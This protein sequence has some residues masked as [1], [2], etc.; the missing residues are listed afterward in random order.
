MIASLAIALII[1][2]ATM[3]LV[4][5]ASVRLRNAGIVDVAWSA[6]FGVIALVYGV[7]GDAPPARRAVAAG[8]MMLWSARLAIHLW[9]R[10]GKHLEQ[11]DGRYAALRERWGERADRR[12]FWFFQFQ[13]LT[14]V[15]LSVPIVLACNHRDP[16]FHLLEWAAVGLWLVAL[17]GESLADAQLRHIKASPANRGLVMDRGLW[18][19]SRHPNY[20][21]EWLIWCSFALFAL[22][23][24]YGWVALLSPALMLWFLLRVTGIPATEEQSLRSRGEA[25]RRYQETTSAFVPLPPKPRERK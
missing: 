25:Y 2:S 20:F 15:A 22:T 5:L 4:W 16:G 1:A 14:N 11:E 7:S 23:A 24:P 17:G 8:M 6:L 18:R 13:G 9:R 10:V 3:T 21:F 12:M 19:Y